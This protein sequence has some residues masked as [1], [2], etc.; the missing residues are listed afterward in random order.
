MSEASKIAARFIRKLASGEITPEMYAILMKARRGV[1]PQDVPFF[2]LVETLKFLGWKTEPIVLPMVVDNRAFIQI[3][4]P[5]PKAAEQLYQQKM[6]ESG[7]PPHPPTVGAFAI[8]NVQ[9]PK[10]QHF[11]GGKEGFTVFY[12]L[13]RYVPAIRITDSKGHE[14]EALPDPFLAKQWRPGQNLLPKISFILKWLKDTST[15]QE[16]AIKVLDMGEYTPRAQTV[17]D[18][19]HGSGTCPACFQV[20]KL[21]PGGSEGVILVLH[22]YQR[23]GWGSTI[24]KCPGVGYPPYEYSPEGTIAQVKRLKTILESDRDRMQELRTT[25]KDLHWVNPRTRK[26]EIMTISQSQWESVRIYLMHQEET[27]IRSLEKDIPALQKMVDTWK[28]RPLTE[29]GKIRPNWR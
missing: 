15:F 26:S 21:K 12:R 9:K 24:G 25:T 22:G 16:D 8:S 3:D 13:W 4:E 2:R 23:P 11:I 28:R 10:K 1:I 17:F 5:D 20:Y 29:A 27:E 6:R 19:K 18:S 14:I 7:M